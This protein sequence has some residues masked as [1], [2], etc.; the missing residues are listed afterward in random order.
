MLTST[1]LPVITKTRKNRDYVT[2]SHTWQQFSPADE[3]VPKSY[4]EPSS[5]AREVFNLPLNEVISY[6]R[7]SS[8]YFKN[9]YHSRA[10][11]GLPSTGPDVVTGPYTMDFTPD[12]ANIKDVGFHYGLRYTKYDDAFSGDGYLRNAAPS[13]SASD[14][15]DLIGRA[16]VESTPT[17]KDAVDGLSVA[18]FI[19]ELKDIKSLFKLFSL[20][21]N[22]LGELRNS[23]NQDLSALVLNYNFGWK[24]FIS[25]LL[26]LQNLAN[27]L[28]DFLDRWNDVAALREVST[29]RWRMDLIDAGYLANRDPYTGITNDFLDTNYNNSY[30][31]YAN[32]KGVRYY[33]AEVEESWELTTTLTYRPKHIYYDKDFL[34]IWFD[35]LGLGDGLSLIWEGIPFSFV[36]DWFLSVGKFLEQFEQ[37]AFE[38]PLEVVDFGYALHWTVS[39]SRQHGYYVEDP[40]GIRHNTKMTIPPFRFHREEYVRRR[41]HPPVDTGIDWTSLGWKFPSLNQ[42]WLALNLANALR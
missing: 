23:F 32:N 36:I 31:G 24:P 2:P 10:S 5:S 41:I 42:W 11:L 30:N 14:F 40:Y 15:R 39:G 20:K 4:N 38:L 16:F 26:K 9:C 29:N 1:T 7:G 21:V 18:N 8:Q 6:E 28:V 19:A 33:R 37:Q 13:L 22:K 27:N 34:S 12:L 3:T 35:A 17:I 25:D